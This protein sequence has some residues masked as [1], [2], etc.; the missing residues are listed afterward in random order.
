ML[1][2]DLHLQWDNHTKIVQYHSASNLPVLFIVPGGIKARSYIARH[3]HYWYG[4]HLAKENKNIPRG[5]D[6]LMSSKR[7]MCTTVDFK[8]KDE[9]INKNDSTFKPTR[10]TRYKV[11]LGNIKHHEP[12]ELPFCSICKDEEYGSASCT[13]KNCTVCKTSFNNLNH[14]QY[15]LLH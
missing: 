6:T 13:N 3:M 5:M 7:G 15:I 8:D 1:G 9:L 11:S 14:T 2:D 10:K 12:V 4:S